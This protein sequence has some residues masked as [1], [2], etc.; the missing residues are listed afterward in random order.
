MAGAEVAQIYLQ[1][2]SAADEPPKRLVAFQKVSLQPG[3]KR[4]VELTI[5]PAATSHPLSIFD[6]SA[7]AW[8]TLPGGYPLYVG[9]SS[10]KV[11]LSDILKIIPGVAAVDAADQP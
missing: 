11:A 1:L 6:S 10:R 7:Q 5:N 2:P 9:T 4:R 3:E 8:K